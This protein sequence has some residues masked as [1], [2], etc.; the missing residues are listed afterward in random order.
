M[1]F[2]HLNEKLL[3]RD[4]S[5]DR[6]INYVDWMEIFKD[7]RELREKKKVRFSLYIVRTTLL[8]VCGDQ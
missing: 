6:E 4:C 7:H 2:S 3:K 5:S 8:E 1:D